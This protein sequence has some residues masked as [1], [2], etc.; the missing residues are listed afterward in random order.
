M[1]MN[2]VLGEFFRYNAWANGEILAACEALED[3]MLDSAVGGTFGTIRQTLVHLVGAQ[4]TF[5]YRLSGVDPSK[6]GPHQRWSAAA[7]AGRDFWPGFPFMYEAADASNA[8]LIAEAVAATGDA[9]IPLPPFQGRSSTA[10]KSFLL[11]H[12][13]EH[14][15][16][17]RTQIGATLAQRGIEPPNL[18]GWGY[19]AETPGLVEFEA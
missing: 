9:A 5:V 12:A 10:M 2:Q 18:D 4:D 14:G 15:M 11:L 3:T 13:F 7:G 17:H 1:G 6:L 19:A 8:A 16:E